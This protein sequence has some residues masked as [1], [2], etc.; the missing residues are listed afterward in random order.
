MRA[1]ID[2]TE[3]RRA[4]QTEYNRQHGITPQSIVKAIADSLVPGQVDYSEL[5]EV[6]EADETYVPVEQ[7]PQKVA[8]LRAAMRKAAADLEFEKAADLRDEIRRLQEY[9][10]AMR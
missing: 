2:E 1:A 9:D 3:R 4:V 8:A 5:P 7:I 10:L 6:A